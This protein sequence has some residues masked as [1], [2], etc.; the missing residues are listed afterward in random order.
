VAPESACHSSE[1]PEDVTAV[2]G[3]LP[4][5]SKPHTIFEIQLVEVAVEEVDK[6]ATV[7]EEY[8]EVAVV[9]LVT[10]VEEVEEARVA[11]WADIIGVARRAETNRADDRMLN[12][13]LY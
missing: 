12:F 1:I 9:E 5:N 8:E 10:A 4:R 7:V 13:I 11:F 6:V 2:V 3:S